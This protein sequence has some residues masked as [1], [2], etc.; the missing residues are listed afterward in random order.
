MKSF[1]YKKARCRVVLIDNKKKKPNQSKLSNKQ[2]LAV[3][4]SGATDDLAILG[5]QIIS[6]LSTQQFHDNILISL[7]AKSTSDPAKNTKFLPIIRATDAW[8]IQD[9]RY[10]FYLTGMDYIPQLD[11]S[12]GE[13]GVAVAEC[14]QGCIETIFSYCF[15]T[16]NKNENYR[17]NQLKMEGWKDSDANNNAFNPGEDNKLF[18][19]NFID[20]GFHRMRGCVDQPRRIQGGYRWASLLVSRQEDQQSKSISMTSNKDLILAYSVDVAKSTDRQ[21][22]TDLNM[23]TA[24]KARLYGMISYMFTNGA[25]VTTL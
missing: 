9:F 7:D 3:E 6:V 22:L 4:M 18:Q 16:Y 2:A 25:S 13:D 8:R 24:P 5:R 15:T 23:Q 12:L 1:V 10:D 20:G 14:R 19:G 17:E 11:R 21:V